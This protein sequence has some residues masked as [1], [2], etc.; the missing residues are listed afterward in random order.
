VDPTVF[1]REIT[2]KVQFLK[3]IGPRLAERLEKLGIDTIADLLQHVPRQY[4]DRSRIARL[5]QAPGI[6]RANVIATVVA[7]DYL[8]F[9]RKRTLKVFV[10]DDSG[11]ASL[12]CFGRNFL[13]QVFVVGRTF[14][15]SGVFTYRF[16]EIQTS[17][18]D[19]LP[20]EDFENKKNRIFPFY[21]LTEG[22]FQK[23][24][25]TA[26]E[27]ALAA[28]GPKIDDE[29]PPSLAERRHFPPKREA[30]AAL[31]FPPDQAMLDRS[32][33]ALI[34]E[35]LFYLQLVIRRAALARKT[36][37]PARQAVAFSLKERLLARLPFRLTDDQLLAVADIEADLF[38]T[39]PLYR[40][41]QGD[42]G[43]GKTLVA[44]IAALDVIEAGEQAAFMAPTE[45][46]ARQHAGS[47]ATL[48]EPLGVRVALLSGSLDAPARGRL[49]AALGAGEINLLIGTHALFSADVVYRRLGL[50]IIDEQHRFGVLQRKALTEKGP[51]PDLLLM[52]ATPIPRSL[53]LTAFGDLDTS[54]IQHKPPGRRA[55][56]THLTRE[57]NETKVYERVRLEIKAGRQAYFV[58][59]LIE[60]SEKVD[61]KNAIQMYEDLSRSVFPDFRLGL[62]H[63]RLSEEEKRTAM[64]KFVRHELDILVATSVVE[65]GVDVPNATAVVI[66]HAER[67][68]LSSLHQLRGRVGRSA[69]QSYAFLIYGRAL[70]PE[71]VRRLKIMLS[72]EDGFVIAEEDLAIRGPGALLG[73]MQ[74]GFLRLRFAD[75]RRDAD[76]LIEARADAHAL[77][78]A[79]PGLLSE[80]HRVVREVLERVPPF[81]A[82][83]LDPG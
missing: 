13:E 65:V 11:T 24:L 73:V 68:G 37:R 69:M 30:L 20:A 70:T 74:S 32:R 77:L 1:L 9:G 15:I 78:T 25:Q 19:Y 2:Q 39:W 10:Q 12:I 21:P 5:S 42:V 63:S 76:T 41:L 75:L 56:I 3:G 53:A 50:V 29:L 36:R 60:E 59:P 55:I 35:E 23:T 45:L 62:I 14:F 79:D 31:H 43:S 61:L 52:T 16:G 71:A 49:L 22:L 66:E 33:S 51:S 80:D 28:Y 54:L 64:D 46:L 82:D 40:L 57:G 58:Y 67:F 26:V 44:L 72:T 17:V 81:H 8:G 47:V 27:R 7:Y 34:Y 38:S 83:L 18:F 48:I 6:E 4:Q